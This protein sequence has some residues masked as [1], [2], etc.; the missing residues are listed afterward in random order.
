LD[1]VDVDQWQI[2]CDPNGDR[3]VCSLSFHT[4]PH[5][6]DQLGAVIPG[7]VRLQ[8]R[9]LQPGQ[10]KQI[11]NQPIQAICLFID[12]CEQVGPSLLLPMH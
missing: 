4:L 8:H 11:A 5:I 6:G 1:I 9:A 7:P 10:I 2:V 12:R 3:M